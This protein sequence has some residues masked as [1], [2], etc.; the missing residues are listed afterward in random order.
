[1]SNEHNK[2]RYPLKHIEL[3][4]T[5]KCS[6]R[7]RHC[8][9][10]CSPKSP[11]TNELSAEEILQFSR[12]IAEVYNPKEIRDFTITGGEPLT[13]KDLFRITSEI[14]DMGFEIILGTNGFFLNP[15]NLDQ[16]WE[17]GVRTIATSIDGM[18]EN[19]NWLRNHS[20]AFKRSLNTLKLSK[21]KGFFLAVKTVINKRNIRELEQIEFL[22]D[23]FGV[24]VW[25]LAKTFPVGRARLLPELFINGA[26]FRVL[27]DF[28]KSRREN[29]HRRMK[30][31]YYD[32]GYLGETYEMK[33]RNTPCQCPAG[34]SIIT[35][36]ADGGITGCSAISR[37][38]IQGNIRDDDII[39]V[40]ENRFQVFRDRRWMKKGKCGNCSM[41]NQCKGDGLHLWEKDGLEPTFC[42]Y[43]LL[44]SD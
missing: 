2:K 33:V 32:E 42:N 31:S 21:E 27:L 4:I 15:R 37:R 36:L 3:E 18:E 5:K 13:R 1:M 20:V 26:E 6:Y 30:I 16:L 8:A 39:D 10:E 9:V 14:V 19:H 11:H 22:L 35:I 40:W 41:V 34:I 28:I 17:A 38:F 7:C 25:L 44:N 24:D 23:F 29:V 43:E 12:R